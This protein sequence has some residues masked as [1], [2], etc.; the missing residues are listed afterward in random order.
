MNQGT[1][2]LRKLSDHDLLQQTEMLVQKERATTLEVLQGLREIEIRRLFVDLGFSSMYEMCI[3]HYKYS[4]GQAQ[5]RLSAARLLKELPEIEGKIQSGSL[6]ITTLAKVQSFVRAE[7]QAHHPLSKTDKLQ[8]LENLQDKST[9]EAEKELVR[10]SHQPELLLGKFN[11]SEK[12]LNGNVFRDSEPVEQ[13][14]KF[15]TLLNQENQKL[16]QEFKELFAH[17][18]PDG[19]ALSVL[20]FLLKKAVKDKKKKLGLDEVANKKSDADEPTFDKPES[21]SKINQNAAQ[22]PS[23]I[24]VTSLRSAIPIHSKGILWKRAQG[25][26]EYTDPKSQRRCNSRFALQTDHVKPV[27]LGGDNSIENLVLLCRAHNS[28]RSIKTFGINSVPV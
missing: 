11:L 1:Q 21:N 16:L 3:K 18:L 8:L 5:R 12:A 24:K 28:R 6:N 13:F 2:N 14:V 22:L 15:E 27:A 20:L 26:C 10:Q 23:S 19:S 25:C 17:E 7:K 9:R 4:E